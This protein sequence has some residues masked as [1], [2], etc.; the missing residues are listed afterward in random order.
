[1]A[2]THPIHEINEILERSFVEEPELGDELT[3]RQA[4]REIQKLVDHEYA[5]WG[6]YDEGPLWQL[7]YHFSRIQQTHW[8]GPGTLYPEAH[9]NKERIFAEL[10]AI[11]NQRDTGVLHHLLAE[12]PPQSVFSGSPG[13]WELVT[14]RDW[15]VALAVI[16]WLG[17]NV[18]QGFI[19]ECEKLYQKRKELLNIS[20]EDRQEIEALDRACST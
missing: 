15:I 10:W 14:K 12:N 8:H 13:T 17:T 7:G 6:N 4:L 1:M 9:V 20:A 11:K 18:G 19:D 16:Q 5:F 2:V 3:P